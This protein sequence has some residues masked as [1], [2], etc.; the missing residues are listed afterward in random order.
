MAG[1]IVVG[2]EGAEPS[3]VALRWGMER[4][5]ALGADVRLVHVVDDE[6][7]TVGS[8]I[9][10]GMLADA[11]RLLEKEAVYARSLVPGVVVSTQ[12]LHGSLMDELIAASKD[13]DL[14][15]V[16]THKTGFIH[17]KI[18]GSRSLMLAAA[19]HSPVAIIPQP[20]R[21][22]GSG[23]V[24]GVDASAAGR[25]AIRFAA[26][27][28]Q[29]ARQTLTL[30]RASDALG[31]PEVRDEVQRQRDRYFE[32]HAKAILS[33]AAAIARSVD[34]DADVRIRRVRRPAAEALVDAAA[35]A[36]LF[37]VGSSRRD[38]E[39]RMM[40]GSVSHDVLINVTVP[41]IVV[42]GADVPES[43]SV[44]ELAVG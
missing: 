31:L 30:V 33:E 27:E 12:L 23:V 20:S 15:A 17:G 42:H 7:A 3:R 16:G 44:E 24:A 1:T 10:D 40:L 35:S 11:G 28:A 19:A 13:A 39:G 34:A 18:F 8:R 9:L 4:A 2:V 14:V 29:R 37:V 21:R 6:W 25:A 38:G 22:D 26:V 32:E 43:S 5:A 36:A 41:T